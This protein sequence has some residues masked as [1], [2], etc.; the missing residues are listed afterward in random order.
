MLNA[1][2]VPFLMVAFA[3]SSE[4]SSSELDSAFL[5]RVFFAPIKHWSKSHNITYNSCIMRNVGTLQNHKKKEKFTND[6]YVKECGKVRRQS[7][8]WNYGELFLRN[9]K[10]MKANWTLLLVGNYQ[11][12]LPFQ[13]SNKILAWFAPILY[14]KIHLVITSKN[15]GTRLILFKAFSIIFT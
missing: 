3:S 4:L 1:N 8:K 14:L 9:A 10:L 6:F 2:N 11:M 13:A 7:K 15:A 12:L 5:M